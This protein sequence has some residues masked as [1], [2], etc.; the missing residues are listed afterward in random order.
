M[1]IT[2]LDVPQCSV[3]EGPVWDV[4]QQS[5]YWIDILEK[6]VLRLDHATGE[7][8]Q[9]DLP[10]II[11]S[12]A[13]RQDGRSALVAL[14]SGVHSLDL[15][16]GICT[17]LATSPDLLKPTMNTAAT[18]TSQKVRSCMGATG[19]ENKLGYSRPRGRI[20]NA[21]KGDVAAAIIAA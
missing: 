18:A 3:G 20:V 8:R 15:R 21:A 19:R 17:M 12:M 1:Q 16:T 5:L 4:E 13:I 9:W 10:E 6:K 11:G 14:A 7:S 2:R